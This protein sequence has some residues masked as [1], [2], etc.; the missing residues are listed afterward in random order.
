MH[1][2]FAPTGHPSIVHGRQCWRPM[3]DAVLLHWD[4]PA[5]T[6][7]ARFAFGPAVLEAGAAAQEAMQEAADAVRKGKI[8]DIAKHG[9]W[10]ALPSMVVLLE[11]HIHSAHG[12]MLRR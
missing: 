3:F 9:G 4:A 7:V 10:S 12:L 2:V 8:P 6:Q 1:W 11:V 5:C